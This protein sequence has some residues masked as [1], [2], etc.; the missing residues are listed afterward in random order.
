VPV[1]CHLLY[2]K[3]DHLFELSLIPGTVIKH[4]RYLSVFLEQHG[5][6]SVTDIQY[7]QQDGSVNV[8]AK[9]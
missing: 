3:N 6:F 2:I 8:V 5:Y 1:F 9:L 4:N 7:G